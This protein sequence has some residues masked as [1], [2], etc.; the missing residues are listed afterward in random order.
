MRGALTFS[1]IKLENGQTYFKNAHIARFLS[2]FDHFS[3]LCMKGLILAGT[4]TGG[5]ITAIL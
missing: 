2:M 3:T 5:K 4:I 1:C